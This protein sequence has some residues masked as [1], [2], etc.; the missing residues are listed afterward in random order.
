MDI[1]TSKVNGIALECLNKENTTKSKTAHHPAPC[2]LN[3]QSYFD[4]LKPSESRLFFAIR[5]GTLD[6]KTFRKYNYEV[7]DVSCRLCQKEEESVE[8]IVNNRC[9]AISRTSSSN[10]DIHSME[11]EVVKMIVDRMKE[12]IKRSEEKEKTA[13]AVVQEM[14]E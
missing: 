4:Y 3:H 2:V 13:V 8:H 5:S 9:E 12:F 14:T 1:V 10:I 7:D 11:K 6:I